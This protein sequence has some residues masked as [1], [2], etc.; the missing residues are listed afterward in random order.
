MNNVIE[1]FKKAKDYWQNM[2]GQYRDVVLVS[3]GLF[4][5]GIVCPKL[6]SAANTPLVFVG[7]GIAIVSVWLGFAAG[8]RLINSLGEDK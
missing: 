1:F 6:V 5:L 2:K 4:N 3:I 7:I 8:A